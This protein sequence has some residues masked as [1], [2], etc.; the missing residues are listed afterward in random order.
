[1][2]KTSR[3]FIEPVR[4]FWS[5]GSLELGVKHLGD[6]EIKS[7]FLNTGSEQNY[8]PLLLTIYLSFVIYQFFIQ[9]KQITQVLAESAQMRKEAD[10]TGPLAELEHWRFLE[11]RFNSFLEQL[12]EPKCRYAIQILSFAK[13]K[14]TRAL[15]FWS[16]VF[17]CWPRNFHLK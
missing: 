5:Q 6:H 7:F 13:S 12:K 2:R 15:I 16:M 10:D 11:A 17:F 1:M 14:E 4:I 9:I 8:S 3:Y